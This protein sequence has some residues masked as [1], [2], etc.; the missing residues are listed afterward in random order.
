MSGVVKVAYELSMEIAS[1][2]P[3]RVDCNKR[4]ALHVIGAKLRLVAAAVERK[5]QKEFAALE[6]IPILSDFLINGRGKPPGHGS[7]VDGMADLTHLLATVQQ[8]NNSS[9]RRE[10]DRLMHGPILP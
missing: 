3:F 8:D 10:D 4:K 9:L 6:L 1:K 2:E 5:P 7:R